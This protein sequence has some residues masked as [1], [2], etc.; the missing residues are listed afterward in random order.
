MREK[1]EQR[2]VKDSPTAKQA[3]DR[4][5]QL[6]GKK[7]SLFKQGKL[8]NP[9]TAK[10][11][12]TGL[13]NTLKA[14]KNEFRR[15]GPE[16]QK[17]VQQGAEELYVRIENSLPEI[18]SKQITKKAAESPHKTIDAHLSL[19]KQLE[20]KGQLRDL[21]TNPNLKGI[22][23]EYWLQKSPTELEKARDDP[24]NQEITRRTY[25]VLMKA[26]EKRDLG[27]RSKR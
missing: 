15:F 13:R 11:I 17:T 23:L 12:L 21:R 4:V 27:K 9:R 3:L 18:S 20:G 19:Q 8:Q 22:N 26:F 14:L 5:S 10:Q 6:L 7:Y 2:Q 24:D 16:S 25:R 1:K